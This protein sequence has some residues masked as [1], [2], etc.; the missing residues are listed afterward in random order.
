G[1]ADPVRRGRVGVG[2]FADAGG[3]GGARQ[4]GGLGH[5]AEAAAAEGQGL[6]G[7][8]AP[9]TPLVPIGGQGLVFLPE[10]LKGT[11]AGH[12]AI[13]PRPANCSSYFFAAPN[14]ICEVAT[15]KGGS[16]ATLSHRGMA[17][18]GPRMLPGSPGSIP[19]PHLSF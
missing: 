15:Q 4:A 2:Q 14:Q 6:P 10:A 7:G 3:H 19:S 16:E 11:G 17:A 9:P 12:P 18:Y 8:P 5:G 13:M 1:A